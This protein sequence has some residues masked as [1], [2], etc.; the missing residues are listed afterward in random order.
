MKLARDINTEICL[1]FYCN[2]ERVVD[3]PKYTQKELETP[4]YVRFLNRKNRKKK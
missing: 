3:I 2:P 4:F 1:P